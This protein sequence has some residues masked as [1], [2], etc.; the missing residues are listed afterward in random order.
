MRIQL[1]G[2]PHET[3]ASDLASLLRE[4]SHA[5]DGVATALNREFVPRSERASTPLGEGDAVEV[6]T[7]MK[8]G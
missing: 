8:G 7:P 3:L 5:P 4:L 1:N 6:L 2:E